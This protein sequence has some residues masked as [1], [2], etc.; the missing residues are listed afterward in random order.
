MR[1]LD[2]EMAPLVLAH[3]GARPTATKEVTVDASKSSAPA[4]THRPRITMTP[5][6]RT[7]P[8]SS[9]PAPAWTGG[10]S[11]ATSTSS[12]RRGKPPT[13][14][15]AARTAR[16]DLRKKM[17]ERCP[18]APPFPLRQELPKHD[19]SAKHRPF[20]VYASPTAALQSYQSPSRAPSVPSP[21][22][23]GPAFLLPP[24]A[25][26]RW[27]KRSTDFAQTAF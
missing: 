1:A 4:H 26:L 21:S 23:S 16:A 5:L 19:T 3:P 20:G 12:A 13:A 27:N 18:G 17:G 7:T 8:A 10:C 2:K 11:S 24:F 25:Q 9:V 22:Q 15:V 14:A 6:R